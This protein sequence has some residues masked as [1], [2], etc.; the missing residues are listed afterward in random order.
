MKL[1]AMGGCDSGKSTLVIKYTMNQLIDE[2]E[3]TVEDSHR[4]QVEVD[5]NQY[6]LD[7]LDTTGLEECSDIRE[8]IKICLQIE[9]GIIPTILVG[10]KSDLIDDIIVKDSEITEVT[11]KYRI[12]YISTSSVDD[13]NV[14]ECFELV[15]NTWNQSTFMDINIIKKTKS[16]Q[17]LSDD[18]IV[19]EVLS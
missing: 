19:L 2:Y 11:K 1:V 3:P 13:I 16:K 6:I 12:P 4:K 8:Y 9:D 18:S 5:G 7:I 14:K 10:T 17:K 15:I